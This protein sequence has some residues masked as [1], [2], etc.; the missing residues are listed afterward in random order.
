MADAETL[1]LAYVSS[2]P[3]DAARVLERQPTPEAASVFTRL[4]ARAAAPALVAMLPTAAARVISASSDS[5]ALGLLTAAGAQGAVA[6]LR[7]VAEPRRSRLIDALPTATALASRLLLGYPEDTVGA[8]ADPEAVALTPETR[9]HEA[10]ARVQGEPEADGSELYVV[11]ADRRLMGVVDL[12]TL[13][14]APEWRSLEGLMRPP[15]AMLSAMMPLA[16]AISHPGWTRATRL[17][18]VARGDRLIGVLRLSVLRE[19]SGRVRVDDADEGMT[20]AGFAAR[21]YWE[22]VAGLVRACL[23][24]LPP[25]KPVAKDEP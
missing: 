5:V 11:G 2:H 23:A 25:A 18:V 6:V 21:G 22:A 15:A 3:V 12:S 17:P 19:A 16:S 8:W 4:P 10:Y 24:L 9:A 7:H 1:T 13:V 14:H 20:L